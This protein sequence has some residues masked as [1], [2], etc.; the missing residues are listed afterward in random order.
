MLIVRMVGDQLLLNGVVPQQHAAG[1]GIFAQNSIG[2]FKHLYGPVG[3]ITQ[4]ANWRWY[5]V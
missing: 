5:Q 1:P 2:V 4:V 3:D